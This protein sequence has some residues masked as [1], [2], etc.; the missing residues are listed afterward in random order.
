MFTEDKMISFYDQSKNLI[1]TTNDLVNKTN[2]L[3]QSN[4]DLNNRMDE[5]NKKMLHK[6]ENNEEMVAKL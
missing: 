6:L 5:F 2:Q 1:E 4:Y 3:K